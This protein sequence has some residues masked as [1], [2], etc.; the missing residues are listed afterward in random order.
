MEKE[1]LETL[2]IDYIDGTLNEADRTTVEREIAKSEEAYGLYQQLREVI[3]AM[4]RSGAIEPGLQLRGSFDKTLR[5]E[6][7][8]EKPTKTIFFQPMIYRAAAAVVLVMAGIGIG[9]WINKNQ[10]L[11]RELAAAKKEAETARQMMLVM[12]DNPQSA[13][14]RIQGVN[15]AMKSEKADNEVVRALAKRMNEDPNTNVR[16]AALEALSKFH[17]EPLVRKILIEALAEQKDP[18]VQIAL[19]QLMVRMKEKNA[20]KDMERIIDDNGTLNAVKDEAYSGILKL[21]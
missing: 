12:M 1:K 7:A 8:K 13:S 15:V 4:D 10:Q 14:Q 2:L 11:E 3:S 20:V 9:F 16:L 18:V 21:S 19:I 5:N 17:E 6:I